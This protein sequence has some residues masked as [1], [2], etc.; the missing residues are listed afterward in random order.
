MDSKEIADQV[1][2]EID[3]RY[4]VYVDEEIAKRLRLIVLIGIVLHLACY[5]IIDRFA[6]PASASIFLK[7]RCINV[8]QLLIV[9]GLS[10]LK[11]LKSHIAWLVD[12]MSLIFIA[13]IGTMVLIS[14]GSGSRYYE[15]ANLVFI[16]VYGIVNPF[17]IGH[18]ICN[19]LLGIGYF[20][21]AML[22]NHTP[23]NS[24]NFLF[25]N[26]FMFSTAI[27]VAIVA[28][29]YKDQHYKV[30]V[31]QEQMK[32]AKEE[33]A[34]SNKELEQ[35]AYVASHDLQEP[36]R[37]VASFCQKLENRYKDKLDESANEYIHFAVDGAKRM[38]IL[39]DG[40]LSYARVGKKDVPIE[41]VD[42]NKIMQTLI[43]DLDT[44][45]KGNGAII[46]AGELPVIMANQI[47]MSQLFQNFLTNALKFKGE[48]QPV[49]EISARKEKEGW[50]FKVSDN[51]I[52]I[53]E[54]HFSKLFVIFNRLHERGS[55]PGTGIGLALCKKIV[56]NYNGNIRVESVFGQGT[57]FHFTLNVK[58][59][60]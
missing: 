59:A 23:F 34:R 52:G 11:Y 10:Y 58:E 48:R 51:G 25:A 22:A 39:V 54:K 17:Y 19:I 40:L 37:M 29:Y 44:V 30:F 33:L 14:N 8:V 26:Y 38:Q 49:V 15:G 3:F 13:G 2:K 47:Q 4:Y 7:I 42:L 45:I 46:K 24:L 56:E 41:R 35:F 27:L 50:E 6:Y 53:E 12:I 28:K 18:I 57:A 16:G 21:F 55:Y 20:E 9:T 5:F 1:K 60:G 36:L 31:Q 43:H 32:M